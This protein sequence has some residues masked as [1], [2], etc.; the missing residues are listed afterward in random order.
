MSTRGEKGKVS[1]EAIDG[2]LRLRWRVHGK[3]YALRI[4]LPDTKANR[5]VAQSKT[6]QIYL[7]VISGNFDP[8]LDKYRP[9]R[10]NDCGL[11]KSVSVNLID[12][13]EQ[14]CKYKSKQLDPRTYEKYQTVG[15]QLKEYHLGFSCSLC[16]STR[17]LPL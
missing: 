11:V 8:T 12:A 6:H 14:F 13:Y 7:D 5:M 10:Q 15:K 2:W 4:G 17:P 3:Q 16:V 1:I 9:P